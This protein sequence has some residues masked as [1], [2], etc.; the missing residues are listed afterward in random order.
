MIGPPEIGQAETHRWQRRED[1]R[2]TCGLD[3]RSIAANMKEGKLWHIFTQT[4]P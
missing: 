2:Q 1:R 3:I 4:G